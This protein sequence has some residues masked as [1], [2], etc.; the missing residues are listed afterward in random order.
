MFLI[1]LHQFQ[2][3]LDVHFEDIRL[4]RGDRLS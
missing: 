4:T 2:A 1:A 3:I